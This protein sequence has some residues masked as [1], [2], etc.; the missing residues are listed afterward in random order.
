MEPTLNTVVEA[1]LAVAMGINHLSRAV[2]LRHVCKTAST[3][4]DACGWVV[5]ERPPVSTIAIQNFQYG[6]K[7][8]SA[9]QI[10]VIQQMVKVVQVASV[11]ISRLERIDFPIG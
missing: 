8:S 1:A 11:F 7:V 9:E 6:G 4:Q 10:Q 5:K 2:F 3:L